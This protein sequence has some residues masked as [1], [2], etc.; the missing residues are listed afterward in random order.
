MATLYENIK[1]LCDERGIKPGK[2]L[3]ETNISK[4][5]M[6]RLKQDP[7]STIEMSTAVKLADYFDVSVDRI[8]T[9]AKQGR[10]LSTTESVIKKFGLPPDSEKPAPTNEDGLTEAQTEF[11]RLVPTL[12]DQELG[13]LLSTAKA[14]IAARQ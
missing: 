4:S 12:T 13:V 10:V 3:V 5:V 2:A 11:I 6:T 9:G 14:L 8:L 7:S 1:A